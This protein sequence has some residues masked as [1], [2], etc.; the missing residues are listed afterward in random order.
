[1]ILH[2]EQLQEAQHTLLGQGGFGAVRVA[3]L[4]LPHG[5]KRVAVKRNQSAKPDQELKELFA[6]ASPPPHANMVRFMGIV[7]HETHLDYVMEL[8]EGGS[9]EALL[10][11]KARADDLRVSP[12]SVSRLLRGVLSALDHLHRRHFIHR[13]VAARN[14]LLSSEDEKAQVAKLADWGTTWFLVICLICSLRSHARCVKDW[15]RV[16]VSAR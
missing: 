9:L 14:I 7:P 2:R 8:V 1:M 12:R 13:D 15:R 10:K 3:C 11:D 16:Q 6:F 5:L 4:V